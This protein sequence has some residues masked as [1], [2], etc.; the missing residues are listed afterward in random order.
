MEKRCIWLNTT[1][2]SYLS[3]GLSTKI[4]VA[5]PLIAVDN[6]RRLWDNFDGLRSVQPATVLS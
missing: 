2:L 5:N 6:F 3:R 1:A 4:I